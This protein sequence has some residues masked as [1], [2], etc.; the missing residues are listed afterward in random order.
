MGLIKKI[1]LWWKTTPTA[2]KIMVILGGV[3]ATASVAGAVYAVHEV[4]NMKVEVNLYPN[5]KDGDSIP[6]KGE[7]REEAACDDEKRPVVF[8]SP[9]DA[10]TCVPT[11]KISTDTTSEK[12]DVWNPDWE[13]KHHSR[14]GYESTRLNDALDALLE[15]GTAEET[16]EADARV[17]DLARQFAYLEGREDEFRER[18][19]YLRNHAPEIYENVET[20]GE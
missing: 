5:G 11:E 2:E 20:K 17:E 19:P 13:L 9:E 18:F 1:K 10:I 7:R 6:L 14:D 16:E 4:K 15:L 8:T 12:W 3:S